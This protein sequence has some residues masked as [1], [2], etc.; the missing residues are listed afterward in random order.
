M[1]VPQKKK[2]VVHSLKSGSS[3]MCEKVSSA[4]PLKSASDRED[5]VQSAKKKRKKT[6]TQDVVQSATKKRKKTQTN[7]FGKEAP[8]SKTCERNCEGGSKDAAVFATVFVSGLPFAWTKDKI[9]HRFA[10]CGR[11]VDVRAPTWQDSGRLRGYAHVGFAS[12]LE[13]EKALQADI[14]VKVGNEDWHLRIEDANPPQKITKHVKRRA[15]SITYERRLFVKN[16]PYDVNETELAA[17]FQDC[18]KINEIRVPTCYGRCKGFAYIEFVKPAFLCNALKLEP[19]PQIRG[20]Q[21]L[22][23]VD[24]GKGPRAGF[25]LRPEALEAGIL[26]A[27]RKAKFARRGKAHKIPLF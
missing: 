17:V 4:V 14:T 27:H 6:Q 3:D 9:A 13:K 16:M 19:P 5:V 18:G 12:E 20:R 22:L 26:G 10:Q 11:V 23:D 24:T 1:P 21:L 15:E 7:G 2:R 25:H 8:V